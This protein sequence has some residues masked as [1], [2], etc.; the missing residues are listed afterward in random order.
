MENYQHYTVEEFIHDNQ[1]RTWVSTE[2]PEAEKFWQAFQER[3]PEQKPTLKAARSLFLAL[4]ESQSIPTDEQGRRIWLAINE[5][6]APGVYDEPSEEEL[7]E[8]NLSPIWG[9]LRAAAVVLVVLGVGW[10]AFWKGNEA[11]A[12]YSAQALES[13]IPLVERKNETGKPLNIEL[14][15]G[16]RIVLY[17]DSRLSY[18][19]AFEDSKR[20]V[21]LSGKAYFEVAEDTTRP[22]LVFAE[23]L[24]TK[25]VGTSFFV[26]AFA[27]NQTPTVEVRTGKVKVFTLEK[28]R[29]SQQGKPEEMLIL[30]ANQQASYDKVKKGFSASRV[31]KTA[32]VKPAE[33]KSDFNFQNVAVVDV[34]KTLETSYGVKIEYKDKALTGCN[35]TAPLGAE[36]LFRKL[37][38]VCQTIGATYEVFETRIVITGSGCM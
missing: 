22:F 7:P 24:V 32:P 4:H 35:I 14:S 34:F 36:P 20:E 18:G 3:Y 15:D 12:T 25:V 37:D 2:N 31:P 27:Q 33:S 21:F 6:T 30:T 5:A 1:F 11:P 10:L 19:K 23:N 26:D 17:P 29:E 16:S 28:F 13:N 9:W 38:I 8:A